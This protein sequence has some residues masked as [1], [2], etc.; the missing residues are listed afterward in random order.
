[1]LASPLP[2]TT[3]TPR[4]FIEGFISIPALDDG[5]QPMR[6]CEIFVTAGIVG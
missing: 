1:M 6:S 3:K 5:A 2:Q 4:Q